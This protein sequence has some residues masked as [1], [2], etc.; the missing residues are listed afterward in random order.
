MGYIIPK[1]TPSA[2][3]ALHPGAAALPVGPSLTAPNFKPAA[4][5]A[6]SGQPPAGPLV[7]SK[8]EVTD[9]SLRLKY[10]CTSP[11]DYRG[12]QTP[13][14]KCGPC[15][16]RK[17]RDQ[18]IRSVL[19]V[20]DAASAAFLTITYSTR[21][22]REAARRAP[23]DFPELPLRKAMDRVLYELRVQA[24]LKRLRERLRSVLGS[25][26]NGQHIRY[27]VV[28]EY[29]SKKGRLHHHALVLVSPEAV[30]LVTS[31]FLRD[32]FGA[33]RH[34]TDASRRRKV[35]LRA[36]GSAR[37]TRDARRLV[38]GGRNDV[39]WLKNPRSRKERTLRDA[40]RAASYVAGYMNKSVAGRIRRSQ[41]YGSAPLAR[42]AANDP[43]FRADMFGQIADRTRQWLR[44]VHG[45]QWVPRAIHKRV[46]DRLK[47]EV[48]AMK[49]APIMDARKALGHLS[50]VLDAADQSMD[51]PWFVGGLHVPKR[52]CTLPERLALCGLIVRVG[53]ND[54]LEAPRRVPAVR[55]FA[56]AMLAHA[57]CPLLAVDFLSPAETGVSLPDAAVAC[58]VAWSRQFDA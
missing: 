16:A 37:F 9:T 15:I 24:G 31:A 42:A 3:F 5:A 20:G 4:P 26:V 32:C 19:E 22:L 57:Q 53:L 27:L 23:L 44:V 25:P 45:G 30:H 18:S 49:R 11:G 12:I 43:A 14:G 50:A 8:S 36:D 13:C 7:L 1:L 39:K 55:V 29:G 34:G 46:T 17:A 33:W 54:L 41:S 35:A 56:P 28:P 21:A 47:L 2:S 52:E 48:S 51:I 10:S 58:R 6:S 40:R 38:V